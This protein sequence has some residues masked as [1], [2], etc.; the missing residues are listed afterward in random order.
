MTTTTFYQQPQQFLT[1]NQ[2]SCNLESNFQNFDLINS[3]SYTNQ[4]AR[5][6]PLTIQQRNANLQTNLLNNSHSLDALNT[7]GLGNGKDVNIFKKSLNM[8]GVNTNSLTNNSTSK[9][10]QQFKNGTINNPMSFTRHLLINSNGQA[11]SSCQL[12]KLQQQTTNHGLLTNGLSNNL[13]NG[14]TNGL[15]TEYSNNLGTGFS[16]ST[17]EVD[18]RRF[19]L[20]EQQQLEFNLAQELEQNAKFNQQNQLNLSNEIVHSTPKQQNN[21]GTLK[22]SKQSKSDTQAGTL[23]RSTSESKVRNICAKLFGT[24][25]SNNS[26]TS[27]NNTRTSIN[28][29]VNNQSYQNSG[30]LENVYSNSATNNRQLVNLPKSSKLLASAV[31]QQ[32]NK[33]NQKPETLTNQKTIR[34]FKSSTN[35]SIDDQSKDEKTSNVIY[36]EIRKKQANNCESKVN[37]IK[38]SNQNA[39]TSSTSTLQNTTIANGDLTTTN[40]KS[41]ATLQHSTTT[42]TTSSST[43][44][45]S[46]LIDDKYVVVVDSSS[47][48]AN[49]DHNTSN[50]SLTVKNSPIKQQ[51]IKSN[52]TS[53]TLLSTDLDQCNQQYN[54]QTANNQ[55]DTLNE[56]QPHLTATT[57][58]QDNKCDE[59]IGLESP[60]T[61]SSES[62]RGT[63]NGKEQQLTNGHQ[64]SRQIEEGSNFDQA[65]LTSDDMKRLKTFKEEVLENW[66]HNK[67]IT[68]NCMV[69]DHQHT[70]NDNT[71]NLNGSN[72]IKGDDKDLNSFEQVQLKIQKLLNDDTLTNDEDFDDLIASDAYQSYTAAQTMNINACL[73]NSSNNCKLDRLSVVNESDGSWLSDSTNA[74]S[75]KT[76]TNSNNKQLNQSTNSQLTNSVNL[77]NSL[78][79]HHQSNSTSAQQSNGTSALFKDKQNQ[80]CLNANNLNNL[81]LNQQSNHTIQQHQTKAANSNEIN[82]LRSQQHQQT[83]M[84]GSKLDEL[85]TPPMQQSSRL[86]HLHHLHQSPKTLKHQTNKNL[87]SKLNSRSIN[88]LNAQHQHIQQQQ[89]Q[90]KPEDLVALI[91]ENRGR[92]NKLN[93]N[94]FKNRSM[95]DLTDLMDDLNSVYT[96]ATMNYTAPTVVK[97]QL[98]GIESMYS[99]V[100]LNIRNGIF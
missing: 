72:K 82:T 18:V 92:L 89:Q 43:T 58:Q 80:P 27:I 14:L 42:T 52:Q 59:K 57:K 22:K 45:T 5:A 44:N 48:S 10:V 49:S 78:Q 62:G 15:P 91:S 19:C 76:K 35:L 93:K 16:N 28:Q 68:A 60:I 56:Q 87:N 53:G 47:V 26:N 39:I 33:L 55:Q 61:S 84:N 17:S 65:S 50:Q 11:G 41:P 77:N 73:S 88:K 96:E 75:S 21:N 4:L 13:S 7:V 85:S 63:L 86:T 64:T 71:N 46:S 30:H 100:G 29:Q 20:T 23:T 34:Q 32:P 12:N 99:E 31:T 70:A 79:S 8:N 95:D 2:I 1:N 74:N 40:T 9:N 94:Q 66:N 51:I 81:K 98:K 36:A 67:L 6:C 37:Q 25:N 3:Q 90:T 97:K 24:S 54:Q 38:Q 69:V 83:I